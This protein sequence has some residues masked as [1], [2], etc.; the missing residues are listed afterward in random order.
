MSDE[1]FKRFRCDDR[2]GHTLRVFRSPADGDFHVAVEADGVH[3]FGPSVRVCS[4]IGGGKHH[5]L[6]MALAALWNPG[7][8]RDVS[9]EVPTVEELLSSPPPSRAAT[10]EDMSDKLRAFRVLTKRPCT[11]DTGKD[12]HAAL[13]ADIIEY[14][15]LLQSRLAALREERNAAQASAVNW[16]A[17][18]RQFEGMINAAPPA[19]KGSV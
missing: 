16:K 15:E 11:F 8:L 17:A 10:A 12:H 13:A 1:L 6:Y 14:V 2:S 19:I 18:A 4:A 7:L 3:G 5:D 9:E